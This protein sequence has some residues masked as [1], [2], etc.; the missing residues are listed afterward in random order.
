M[1][2]GRQVA[3]TWLIQQQSCTH[4]IQDKS[5]ECDSLQVLQ[6]AMCLVFQRETGSH[7][8][9]CIKTNVSGYTMKGLTEVQPLYSDGFRAER[10]DLLSRN[11]ALVDMGVMIY[12]SSVGEKKAL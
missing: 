2:T 11:A 6:A 3:S 12:C 8:T 9:A 7:C 10:G 1:L 4:E 5:E